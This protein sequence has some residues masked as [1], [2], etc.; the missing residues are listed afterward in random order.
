MKIIKK[1]KEEIKYYWKDFWQV[2][3]KSNFKYELKVENNFKKNSTQEKTT[4]NFM[5]FLE[6]EKKEQDK[7]VSPKQRVLNN[8][9]YATIGQVIVAVIFGLPFPF[10]A[11]SFFY[12]LFVA[13]AMFYILLGFMLSKGKKWAGII[14]F[15]W[16]CLDKLLPGIIR[17]FTH[18]SF[19]GLFYF[20][21]FNYFFGQFYYKAL[22]CLRENNE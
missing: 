13:D 22:R 21:L 14:L 9:F 17:L 2:T 19:L 20:V 10:Q 4:K 1:I 6:A 16:F 18:F 3:L 15:V 12:L 7:K 5:E 8:A 11:G